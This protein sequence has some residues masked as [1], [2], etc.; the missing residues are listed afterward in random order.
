MTILELKQL[1][2]KRINVPANQMRLMVASQ[3]ITDENNYSLVTSFPIIQNYA[4]VLILLRLGAYQRAK[5]Y[6]TKNWSRKHY[7]TTA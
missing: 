3:T 5:K 7:H 4:T 6:K 1:I 2:E